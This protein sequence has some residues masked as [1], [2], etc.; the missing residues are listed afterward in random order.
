MLYYLRYGLCG[1]IMINIFEI[2]KEI[3]FLEK[4]INGLYK[5]SPLKWTDETLREYLEMEKQ[6]SDLRKTKGKGNE[7]RNSSGI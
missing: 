7:E 2:E 6:I 4:Q 3:Y 1:N 5:N